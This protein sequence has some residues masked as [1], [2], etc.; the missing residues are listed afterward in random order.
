MSIRRDIFPVFLVLFF[1][2]MARQIYPYAGV[3]DPRIVDEYR[4][5]FHI[6]TLTCTEKVGSRTKQ[7]DATL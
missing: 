2:L 6:E 4:G 3:M 5:E 7:S 1:L